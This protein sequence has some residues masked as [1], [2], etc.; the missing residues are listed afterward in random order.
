MGKI[1]KRILSLMLSLMILSSVVT[2]A[3]VVVGAT[4]EEVIIP[5]VPE[6]PN[7][8]SDLGVEK[9]VNESDYSSVYDISA[10]SVNIT[11]DGTYLIF[12]DGNSTTN[13]ITVSSEVK[14][15]ITLKNVCISA[16]Q[17]MFCDS[18]SNVEL[19]IVGS[20]I[21]TSTSEGRAGLCIPD[22]GYL[23]I[24]SDNDKNT[25]S[26]TSGSYAAG[27][28][29]NNVA[30]STPGDIY[31]TGGSITAMGNWGAGIGGSQQGNVHNIVI[32]GGNIDS[33]SYNYRAAGIGG[34]DNSSVIGGIYIS[35]GTVYALSPENG[36]GI[37][38][39]N[40]GTIGTIVITGG[41]ITAIGNKYGSGIGA[42]SSSTVGNIYIT[43]GN[44][45][46]SGVGGAGIGGGFYGGVNGNIYISNANINAS[47][48]GGAGIGSGQYGSLSGSINISNSTVNSYSDGGYSIGSGQ[49]NDSSTITTIN[50]DSRSNVTISANYSDKT[51]NA[52]KLVSED[53]ATLTFNF[54]NTLS[55]TEL[56]LLNCENGSTTIISISKNTKSAAFFVDTNATYKLI[57][58]DHYLFSG[59]DGTNTT[60]VFSAGSYSS[61]SATSEIVKFSVCFNVSDSSKVNFIN[62]PETQEV[63]FNTSIIDVLG[64]YKVIDKDYRACFIIS[65][66]GS[67]Q[68]IY[69]P[70]DLES[71]KI[72]ADTVIT[73]GFIKRDNSLVVF[74]PDNGSAITKI[75]VDI[76][77]PVSIPD[78]P[79]KN[80]HDF[81]GW[82]DEDGNIWNFANGVKY[83]M[84]LTAKWEFN[85]DK[86]V[87]PDVPDTLKELDRDKP[88]TD[89]D[90]DVS[91]NIEENTI[92]IGQNGVYL[93]YGYNNTTGNYLEIMPGVTAYVTIRNINV[94][95][96]CFAIKV[97]NKSHVTLNIEGDNTCASSDGVWDRYAYG[98]MTPATGYCVITAKDNEQKLS[99]SGYGYM[100]NSCYCGI[101]T[102]T[103]STTLEPGDIYIT[104]GNISCSQ[105]TYSLNSSTS[106]VAIGAG[107]T[108]VNNIVITGGI[109][110]VPESM[111]AI[112][113]CGIGAVLGG[114][115]IKNATITAYGN[116]RNV[117]SRS[118][119][120]S[121]GSASVGDIIIT[122]SDLTLY[123][124]NSTAYMAAAIGSCNNDAGTCGDII[125]K[126]SKISIPQGSAIMGIGSAGGA[127]GKI[128]ISDSQFDMSTSHTA[129]GST[130]P[131]ISGDILINNCNGSLV[132]GEA[133]KATIGGSS[134]GNIDIRNSELSLSA[135][136][137]DGLSSGE[138]TTIGASSDGTIG[139]INISDTKINI[140]GGTE[141]ISSVIGAGRSNSTVGDI[142]VN[143]S[144]I[145][146]GEADNPA[147]LN[148]AVIG[149]GTENSTIGNVCINNSDIFSY[150]SHIGIGVNKRYNTAGNSTIGNIQI[151]NSHLE[152]YGI[153][154]VTVGAG[155]NCAT[156]D[157]T[158]N[159]S[160][161]I[162]EGY[163]GIGSY[164]TAT[165]G[166]IDIINSDL[167]LKDDIT[168]IGNSG[169]ADGGSAGNIN[170]DNSTVK[171]YS[172]QVT[173][174][175]NNDTSTIGNVVISDNSDIQLFSK[176]SSAIS[177]NVLDNTENIPTMY[178]GTFA[179][180]FDSDKIVL[181]DN[182]ITNSDISLL[183]GYKTFAVKSV[184]DTWNY[185]QVDD[186]Y[187]KGYM[188]Y[189]ESNT[190]YTMNYFTE[191]EIV[192]KYDGLTQT[193]YSW[194][195]FETDGK[196][197]I[198]PE[199]IKVISGGKL[200]YLP[201]VTPN[202]GYK[203][204]HWSYE[205]Y[206]PLYVTLGY[207]HNGTLNNFEDIMD[208]YFE[209]GEKTKI[210]PSEDETQTLVDVELDYSEEANVWER[211]A[212]EY[213]SFKSKLGGKFVFTAI[214]EPLPYDYTVKYV[215]EEG[216][217]I[218]PDKVAQGY[219]QTVVTENP[220]AIKG[221]TPIDKS[222]KS[223]II[224][225]ENNEIVF[226]YRVGSAARKLTV[227]VLEE[228]T[229]L[230]VQAT[231][232]I[233]NS[234]ASIEE[235]LNT[236]NNGYVSTT[237]EYEIDD[238]IT[239][240]VSGLHEQYLPVDQVSYTVN[241][242][243]DIIYIYVR[244]NDRFIITGYDGNNT[245]VCFAII[246]I[247][248]LGLSISLVCIQKK[249]KKR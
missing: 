63:D 28:G 114:V 186:W 105:T 90:Y 162:G 245:F 73:L 226:V 129:I 147:P 83:D 153:G 182:A 213:N 205:Y 26:V 123:S 108:P 49:N 130:S 210:T 132:V 95:R 69:D 1:F 27:I 125:I 50:I 235:N 113:S 238:T 151:D 195:F 77:E 119:I 106:G 43:D 11:S 223:I 20:N 81:M 5:T 137:Y 133:N 25:L 139:N 229:N 57:N 126:S 87:F 33:R 202:K 221:Y 183:A 236:D 189:P 135:G 194:I 4:E 143:A 203:Y 232:D 246:A 230:G 64:D 29:T 224:D 159:K 102:S 22:N 84:T 54:S 136:R 200:P 170:I 208:W 161:V 124:N 216:N 10:G 118:I 103:D 36:A 66:C 72:T 234:D 30:T 176:G 197:T 164:G 120:G 154:T 79:E 233:C 67:E 2:S 39:G 98:I 14:A 212:L 45:N 58:S 17:A 168:S 247:V 97:G 78:E 179:N 171:A 155:E 101:G 148:S 145:Q 115:Y 241:S 163:Y 3:T 188:T 15:Y 180:T 99:A 52:D 174:G 239:I 231:L 68:T 111:T 9:P 248:S 157:I 92:Q 178:Q 184:P 169:S 56:Y 144:T 34:G 190:E 127:V 191:K 80:K 209:F 206:T 32:T 158:I 86:I 211:L 181:F 89:D 38:G 185:V 74:N 47:G 172:G 160:S 100:N 152:L 116:G 31:I 53:K 35:G 249:R 19:N 222:S 175:A 16:G 199:S 70:D 142:N 94:S 193:E 214:Q 51:I 107:L 227:V 220:I 131:G 59:S 117:E 93:V 244:K 150:S 37:G 7:I 13:T 187:Y 201:T 42:G 243:D 166:N 122:D 177:K 104:G 237:S 62:T 12:G 96:N 141:Y 192:T 76:N 138:A 40:A 112:G 165:V 196:A 134:C 21:L 167:S 110:N 240:N 55:N 149:G 88:T 218:A 8:L 91:W 61:V 242:D 24:S 219:Y 228:D 173:L 60:S 46:A 140:P 109:I 204:S 146:V 225:F 85:S 18:L 156:G 41:I 65:S 128:S 48:V 75:T 6:V 207:A 217:S 215:D 121:S 82:F 198:E 23:V 71:I 44:I